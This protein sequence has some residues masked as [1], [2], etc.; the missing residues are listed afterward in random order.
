M[1][2]KKPVD[3]PPDKAKPDPEPVIIMS[4]SGA[5]LYYPPGKEPPG[6]VKG[7]LSSWASERPPRHP[8]DLFGIIGFPPIDPSLSD[9]ERIGLLWQLWI[10]RIGLAL[11]AIAVVEV[12]LLNLFPSLGY[13]WGIDP[14]HITFGYEPLGLVSFVPLCAALTCW[15][16]V[17]LGRAA[18]RR[19]KDMWPDMRAARPAIIGALI[20]LSAIHGYMFLL[21]GAFLVLNEHDA[22]SAAGYSVAPLVIGFGWTLGGLGWLCGSIIGRML[23]RPPATGEPAESDQ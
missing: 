6:I 4:E 13:W 21:S 3:L 10:L 17:A 5:S 2:R 22:D 16:F 19:I 7:S 18:N 23:R 12:L 20:G 1:V 11:P 8:R 14:K 15:P 9:A